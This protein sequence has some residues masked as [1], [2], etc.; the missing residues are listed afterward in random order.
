LENARVLTEFPSPSKALGSP[1]DRVWLS[2]IDN[3]DPISCCR[4]CD[5]MGDSSRYT[6]AD[7]CDSHI[8]VSFRRVDFLAAL[9]SKILGQPK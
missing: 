2:R 4:V 9:Q 1:T 3:P 6:T 5:S 8:H 7:C